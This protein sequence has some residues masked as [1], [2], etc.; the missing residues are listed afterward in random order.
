M[1]YKLDNGN[2]DCYIICMFT[3]DH[4]E[5]ILATKGVADYFA[6]DKEYDLLNKVNITKIKDSE[7]LT[8]KFDHIKITHTSIEWQYI[9]QH[10]QK[11]ICT[12]EY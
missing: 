10:E 4:P 3:E 2:V 11:I 7:Y 6:E 9:Y 12:S 8:F 5:Q 1:I